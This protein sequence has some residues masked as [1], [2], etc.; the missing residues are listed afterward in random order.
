[1]LEF[2]QEHRED[3]PT[4]LAHAVIHNQRM[5]GGELAA[6]KGFEQAVTA[7]LERIDT[8]GAYEAMKECLI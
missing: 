4:R 3:G 1:M 2:Y 8:V 6:L 5:W 7:A